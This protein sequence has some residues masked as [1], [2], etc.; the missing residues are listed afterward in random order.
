[1]QDRFP[2]R[3]LIASLA[4]ELDSTD[5]R[6]IKIFK[7]HASLQCFMPFHSP[8]LSGLKHANLCW[9]VL[10]AP[11]KNQS[12]LVSYTNENPFKTTADCNIAQKTAKTLCGRPKLPPRCLQHASKMP[13]AASNTPRNDR[14]TTKMLQEAS[15]KC[16]KILQTC[17]WHPKTLPNHAQDASE[18]L[19]NASKTPWG[20]LKI[21][22]VDN[23]RTLMKNTI[24]RPF[25][26]IKSNS[27]H[28]T[29]PDCADMMF[30]LITSILQQPSKRVG[31]LA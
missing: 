27:H 11:L 17:P 10:H 21:N 19:Q 16:K 14:K 30:L 26:V 22:H 9:R 1:M 20:G 2:L 5:T 12:K 28:N 24:V 18:T 6:S 23:H 29:R 4:F 25:E 3:C 31:A 15:K 8:S 7:N 13:Q